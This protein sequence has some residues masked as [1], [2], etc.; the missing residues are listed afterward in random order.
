MEKLVWLILIIVAIVYFNKNRDNR[1]TNTKKENKQADNMLRGCVMHY[2]SRKLLTTYF[3]GKVYFGDSNSCVG[4][5]DNA[6]NVYRPDGK[7]I[8][9]VEEHDDG[10][11]RLVLDRS[12]EW[13]WLIQKG[14]LV[15]TENKPAMGLLIA[16]NYTSFIEPVVDKPELDWQ[17]L[18]SIKK[19]N[20]DQRANLL[21]SSAAFIVAVYENLLD[22]QG[23][24]FYLNAQQESYYIEKNGSGN[25]Y[26][27]FNRYKNIGIL[28][29]L[30]D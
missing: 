13:K 28:V 17:C 15:K 8:G 21:G 5:Y 25:Y 11:S 2:P 10:T 1:N 27:K 14:N 29:P 22:W 23:N 6:G 16:R 4:S 24:E 3:K 7:R 18:A 9:I 20:E 30:N 12:F 26:S 19:S